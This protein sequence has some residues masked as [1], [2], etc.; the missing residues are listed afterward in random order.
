MV[1]PMRGHSR[2]LAAV[3][4]GGFAAASMTLVLFAWAPQSG[5]QIP[6]YDAT[7]TLQNTQYNPP[8]TALP[9][10]GMTVR[11]IHRDGE[12]P[13]SVTLTPKPGQSSFDSHP[14]C[15]NTSVEDCWQ[16]SDSNS[17]GVFIQ[18]NSAGVY[19]Y[20]CKI[21]AAMTGSVTVE[22][23]S[24]TVATTATT[25]G[26]TTTRATTATTVGTLTTTSTTIGA[27]TSSSSALSTTSSSGATTSSIGF[28]T[29]TTT[30]GTA[31]GD[32]SDD[33]DKPSGVLQ[34][35]G[36]LLLAAVVAALIPAW[37]R[38]T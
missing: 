27:T 19:N 8:A 10:A 4:A 15:S 23:T 24:P 12:T 31:L 20:H 18:F 38:L 3:V 16:Q 22:G 34:A 26:T 5:A 37:R 36:V 11:W 9:R 7:V 28:T 14:A 13:H 30:G 2:G 29:Q 32:K 25:R 6:A 17:D 33:D 21:H 1:S 35:A